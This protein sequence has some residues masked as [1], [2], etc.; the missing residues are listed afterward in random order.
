MNQRWHIPY[1]PSANWTVSATGRVEHPLPGWDQLPWSK[2]LDERISTP[3][4]LSPKTKWL[5]QWYQGL[6]QL[7]HKNT[8]KVGWINHDQSILVANLKNLMA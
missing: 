6:V 1:I 3:A 7:I 5:Y 8:P 2:P 4:R